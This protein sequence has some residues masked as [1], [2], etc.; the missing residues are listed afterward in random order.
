MST[1]LDSAARALERILG[2][3]YPEHDWV[4]MRREGQGRNWQRDAAPR[5]G[6]G[7][8]RAVG[9]DPRA[10]LDRDA[11]PAADRGDEH[12]LEEAA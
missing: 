3:I 2:E 11:L 12:A 8:A 10:L 7:Q 6:S 9:D 1:H 5:I 4:V